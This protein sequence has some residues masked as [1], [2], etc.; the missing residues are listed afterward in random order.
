[1]VPL[2]LPHQYFGKMRTLFKSLSLL[3]LGSFAG[4]ALTAQ[5]TATGPGYL[6]SWNWQAP[7]PA[8]AANLTGIAVNGS[9]AL[10]VGEAGQV[11][12]STITELLG[13]LS[14]TPSLMASLLVAFANDGGTFVIVGSGGTALRSTDNGLSWVSVDADTTE[15]LFD[16]ARS[17]GVWMA[18][19]ASGTIRRSEDGG[20]TW[21][22][23]ANPS[24]RDLRAVTFF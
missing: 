9:T 12:R 2:S 1:M 24:P 15:D 5:T 13:R 16:L 11:Q 14:T 6:D 21:S 19:G 18:V 7:A 23:V 3:L 17:N 4:S 22:P 8:D 20:L 10:A